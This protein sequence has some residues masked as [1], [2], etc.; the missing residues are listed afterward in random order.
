MQD[1]ESE[2]SAGKNDDTVDTTFLYQTK[3]K[4]PPKRVEKPS[5]QKLQLVIQEVDKEQHDKGY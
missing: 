1:E 5:P 2:I 4:K 3:L